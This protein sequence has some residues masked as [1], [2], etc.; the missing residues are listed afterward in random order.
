MKRSV[1]PDAYLE[2]YVVG[3]WCAIGALRR[4]TYPDRSLAETMAQHTTPSD[5]RGLAFTGNR[6]A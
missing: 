3:A 6:R 1:R 5:P 4:P 2:P